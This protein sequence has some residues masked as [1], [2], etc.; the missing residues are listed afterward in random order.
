[1]DL[2]NIKHICIY[3]NKQFNHRSN[4]Y[5][6]QK[7]CYMNPNHNSSVNII[8]PTVF[9]ENGSSPPINQITNSN[10]FFNI[11]KKIHSIDPYHDLIDVMGY[12]NAI[13]FITI[14]ILQ[15]NPLNIFKKIYTIT[16]LYPIV[17]R[18][19]HYRYS[20][21]T[22][23]IDTINGHNII[24]LIID[25]IHIA[26]IKANIEIINKKLINNDLNYLYDVYEIGKVQNNLMKLMK[27]QNKLKKE[28]DYLITV[29]DHPYYNYKN[30]IID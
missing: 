11:F 18:D 3:C 28:F 14:C 23:L 20:N 9:N 21:G 8:N 16:S 30:V 26:M 2:K 22:E 13:N 10:N 5:A 1:M 19:Y 24:N 4:K 25:K 27:L 6:H 15:C 17:L 12:D 29:K 7:K